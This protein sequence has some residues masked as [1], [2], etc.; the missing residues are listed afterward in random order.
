MTPRRTSLL[1]WLTLCVVGIGMGVVTAAA[2]GLRSRPPALRE[3]AT[4][5]AVVSGQVR[6][7]GDPRGRPASRG[8]GRL[9]WSISGQ[10][11]EVV[12]R[13]QQVSG[14][15]SVLVRGEQVR[16]W[17]YGQRLWVSLRLGPAAGSASLLTA[18]VLGIRQVTAAPV[19]F[20]VAESVRDAFREV[21]QRAPPDSAGL[22]VG[23]AVGDD[24]MVSPDLSD[25]MRQAGLTHLTAVSGS[26]T[27][28]VLLIA[29]ALASLLG[30]P[31]LG[32][33][34]AAAAA[35]S[36]YVI[37]VHP[38]P[39]VLRAAVMGAIGL[40]A[41]VRGGRRGGVGVLAA[42]VIGLLAARP[43]MAASLGF[44]LS[45]C[46]TAGLLLAAGPLA[47]RIGGSGW[48]RWLPRPVVLAAAV[49]LAAQ[50]FTLP[51]TVA[52]GNG[53]SPVS[54]PANLAAAPVVP[55]ITVLGLA[56]ALLA[57][58]APGPAGL[59]VQ[60]A[61]PLAGYIARVARWAGG[62]PTVSWPSGLR[63]GLLM[64]LAICGIAGA[65]RLGGRR[66]GGWLAAAG[67]LA[68]LVASGHPTLWL[69]SGWPP[70]GWEVVSCD[71]GQGDATVVRIAADEAILVDAG[72]DPAAVRRCLRDLRVSVIAAVFLT[73]YHAD[74]IDGLPGVLSSAQVGP[75]F[76][77]PIEDP[78]AGARQVA[79]QASEAGLPV[80]ALSAGQRLEVGGAH[81]SVLWPA[82]VPSESVPNNSSLVLLLELRVTT[83]PGQA[84]AKPLRIL[85]T[86]DVEPPIQASLM[87][88]VPAEAAV[89]K[90]PHHGSSYQQPG[91]PEWTGAQVALVSVGAGND[92]GHPAASALAAYEAA[93]AHVFRTDLQGDVAV[94]WEAAA[95]LGVVSRR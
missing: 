74:H 63:G 18:Q 61:A 17:R 88:G 56:A 58:P 25:A 30:L 37:L 14:R 40:L 36:G 71:V 23:L 80:R 22:L 52:L 66:A 75:V 46:A 9:V 62:L 86:G 21:A 85:L 59:L 28:L 26:N 38:Q 10:L 77:T 83:T 68:V 90:V 76:T 67:A 34:S 65:L 49:T 60:L 57:A 69:P 6:V 91:F 92:Y 53:L 31:L 32:R 1:V 5:R 51:L 79:R 24:S 11:S 45:A 84:A 82:R 81:I 72:P 54:L 48:G 7:S 44:G 20:R 64:V 70:D 43:E 19:A 13:G 27:S 33:V 15:A 12:A 29:F 47:D 39:S 4:A 42:A 8:E 50:L 78:E 55:A 41:V 95:G 73:H 2:Y 89:V 16:A 35:L 94:V 93:G 3:L 87:A